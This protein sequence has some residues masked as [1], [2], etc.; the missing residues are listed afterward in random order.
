MVALTTERSKSSTFLIFKKGLVM[1]LAV[2]P[3]HLS[4]QGACRGQKKVRSPGSG[5]IAGGGV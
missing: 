4:V 2:F 5:V 1:H 3:A